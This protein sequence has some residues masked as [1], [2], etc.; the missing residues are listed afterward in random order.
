[1][2]GYDV[3]SNRETSIPMTIPITV[4]HQSWGW[5]GTPSGGSS[6]ANTGNQICA[7]KQYDLLCSLSVG[8]ESSSGMRSATTSMMT[9]VLT[10]NAFTDTLT[11][12]PVLPALP[13]A[14]MA[15]LPHPLRVAMVCRAPLR[16]DL[17][18]DAGDG[19]DAC[20]LEAGWLCTDAAPTAACMGVQPLDAIS[21]AAPV[22]FNGSQY[23]SGIPGCD[24]Q[25]APDHWFTWTPTMDG[26][27]ILS[28]TTGI[29][30]IEVQPFLPSMGSIGVYRGSC[31]LYECG[32]SSVNFEANAGQTVFFQVRYLYLLI[33]PSTASDFVA[34]P[35]PGGTLPWP[36]QP[37]GSVRGSS[38]GGSQAPP[39]SCNGDF[40]SAQ[41]SAQG[42]SV[43]LTL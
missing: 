3:N 27:S 6:Q 17:N 21:M 7:V 29:F 20:Q 36:S 18:D 13:R 23:N 22:S 35:V 1:M 16:T 32:S 8:T 25:S 19:C 10:A 2:R 28:H 30:Q 31:D 34:Y 43:S 14:V 37:G 39:S 42:R 24:Y 12:Q 26:R 38:P 33:H 41:C 11:T 40:C 15:W 9:P 4:E 5:G